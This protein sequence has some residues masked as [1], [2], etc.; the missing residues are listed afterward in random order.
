MRF[1]VGT[2]G[3][4]HKEWKG[5]FY[6]AKIS[7]KDMLPYFA[8]RFS[9]VEMNN[10]FYR[11]PTEDV[12][13]GWAEQVPD[14]FRFIIK[15]PQSIT[16][17]KRLKGAEQE[18][19]HLLRTAAVLKERLGPFLFQLPPNLKKDL[20]RLEA[21]L[22]H[23]GKRGTIAFE[24]RHE[25][26]FDDEVMSCLRAH[27]CALCIA[28]TEDFPDPEL[29]HT[30]GWGYVRL[31]RDEYTDK[32]LKNWVKKLQSQIWD[33]VYVFF[34]HEETGSGPRL[35]ARLIELASA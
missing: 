32:D 30:A 12:M 17:R 8:E 18:V 26:W 25:S 29:I 33:D 2:S 22:E 3:Y 1:F 4:S 24:F 21:F 15:A 35:G 27:S 16:H 13:S 28:D 34:K 20:A 9:T 19:D 7:P 5:N 11:M 31:R 6:P 23:L 10:T 14:N